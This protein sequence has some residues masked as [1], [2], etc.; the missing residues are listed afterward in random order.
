MIVKVLKD[1]VQ[2]TFVFQS[3]ESIAASWSASYFDELFDNLIVLEHL[4]L[5]LALNVVN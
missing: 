2:C 1:L 3:A 4:W 5:Q